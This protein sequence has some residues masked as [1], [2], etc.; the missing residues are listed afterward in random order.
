MVTLIFLPLAAARELVQYED[1][2]EKTTVLLEVQ[3]K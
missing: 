1:R 2:G 3:P